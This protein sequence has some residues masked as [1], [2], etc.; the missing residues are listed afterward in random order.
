MAHLL[1]DQAD[2]LVDIVRDVT[3]QV[4]AIEDRIISHQTASRPKLGRCA[5]CSFG[6]SD[7]SRRNPRHSSGC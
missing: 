1:R 2:V 4:D 7:C 6:C 5:A 3:R